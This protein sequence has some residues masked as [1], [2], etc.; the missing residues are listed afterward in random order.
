MTHLAKNYNF[1][2]AWPHSFQNPQKMTTWYPL[3]GH[4]DARRGVDKRP[5]RLVH[6]LRPLLALLDQVNTYRQQLHKQLQHLICL[7]KKLA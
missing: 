7:H 1:G 3:P 4:L 5:Q 6:V 2:G